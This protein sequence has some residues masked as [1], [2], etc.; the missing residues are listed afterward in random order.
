M[1]PEPAEDQKKKAFRLF[2][3]GRY[4]ES[5][6]LCRTLVQGPG[7]SEVA[8][9]CATNLF[10]LGKLDEAEAYFRD[11]SV[12]L[13]ASSHVH[14]YLGRILARRADPRAVSEYA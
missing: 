3:L 5:Y 8:V 7:D 11:L 13:P 12:S 10:H 14:S 2:E 4:L 9:L 1:P 6:D